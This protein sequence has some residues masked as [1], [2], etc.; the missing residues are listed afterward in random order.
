[1]NSDDHELE[2]TY[3]DLVDIVVTRDQNDSNPDEKENDG[4]GNLVTADKGST[5]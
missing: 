1:M 4:D 2:C 3:E 5:H